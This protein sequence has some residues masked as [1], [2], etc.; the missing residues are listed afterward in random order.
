MDTPPPKKSILFTGILPVLK[1]Q[2]AYFSLAA[3]KRA[4]TDAEIDLADNTL[5]EYMS[6]A[7]ASDCLLKLPV[8][9]VRL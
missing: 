1:E 6:E 2:S 4:L 9:W 3:V 5:R 8:Q 7:M